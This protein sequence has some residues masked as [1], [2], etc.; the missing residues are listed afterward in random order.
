MAAK[1]YHQTHKDRMH[2]SRGEERAMHR[3]HVR[4]GG[5]HSED[6]RRRHEME[7][8]GMIRE[9]HNATANLPQDVKYHAWP[10][11]DTYPRYGLDDTIRGIDKQE[12]EDG[13]KMERH[14]Q[15]GKY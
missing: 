10:D 13:R 14:M 9:D 8:A 11:S 4:H 1:R 2:E 5:H 6:P 3:S 15:F 12:S 7:D